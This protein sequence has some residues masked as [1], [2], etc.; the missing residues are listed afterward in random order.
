MKTTLFEVW[1]SARA[2]ELGLIEN[3][4]EMAKKI[5]ED[6]YEAVSTASVLTLGEILYAI[7]QK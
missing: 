4:K 5:F 6:V 2:D 1:W 3:N 7:T